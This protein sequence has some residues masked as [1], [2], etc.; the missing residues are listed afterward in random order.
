M[1]WDYSTKVKNLD[2]L[3][4]IIGDVQCPSC[5]SREP[6]VHDLIAHI[7]TNGQL[8]SNVIYIAFPVTCGA[9]GFIMFYNLDHSRFEGIE[10]EGVTWSDKSQSS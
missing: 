8:D 2:D 10:Q 4:R 7:S 9:C 5:A 1:A 6:D 3:K